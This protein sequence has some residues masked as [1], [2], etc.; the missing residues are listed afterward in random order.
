MIRYGLKLWTKNRDW[1][2]EAKVRY[3]E[4]AFDFI[5][6]YFHPDA[7]LDE[8]ALRPLAG[9]PVGVHAPHALDEFVFG[10]KELE[11]WRK[12]KAFV[13][14]V[15]APTVVL[16]PGYADT[17]PDF[18]A[19][20][21]ELAK[22][23]DPRILIETMPGKDVKGRVEFGADLETWKRIRA[24]KPMC[25]DFEKAIKAALWQKQEWKPY[26]AEA[27]Q[28]LAP[29]YF[30]ISGCDLSHEFDQHT[31]LWESEVDWAFVKRALEA[32]PGDARL[33]FETPKNGKDLSNDLDNMAFFR[34]VAT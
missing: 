18:A 22:I 23:D 10:E 1:F 11:L 12:T 34:K 28:A 2:E 8:E 19:F 32:V 15:Q 5:E 25:L 13:D 3:Q 26:I 20:E 27:M 31:D 30:H 17:I 7:P 9:I 24:K 6:L 29:E 14:E 4:G 16:H 33:V 21:R